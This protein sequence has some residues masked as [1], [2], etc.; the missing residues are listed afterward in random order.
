MFPAFRAPIS[1]TISHLIRSDIANRRAHEGTAVW[2]RVG[3]IAG[4]R[5]D[6]RQNYPVRECPP[7]G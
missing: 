6:D 4:A 1:E 2:M 7:G 5:L 3:K